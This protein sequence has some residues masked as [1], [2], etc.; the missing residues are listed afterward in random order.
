MRQHRQSGWNRNAV[1]ALSF[2]VLGAGIVAVLA[3]QLKSEGKRKSL[4]LVWADSFEEKFGDE[5][6][7]IRLEQPYH[8]YGESGLVSVLNPETR[9]PRRIAI[10]KGRGASAIQLT[11]LESWSFDYANSEPALLESEQLAF[12]TI[13]ISNEE[14]NSWKPAL[15]GPDEISMTGSGL[16]LFDEN[17]LQAYMLSD[18]E[19]LAK[20]TAAEIEKRRRF[21]WACFPL[22]LEDADHCKANVVYT[23]GSYAKPY[24]GIGKDGEI[25]CL[26]FDFGFL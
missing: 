24:L 15:E 18:P 4:D 9:A 1:L 11:I 3:T 25:V 8:I 22:D 7:R 26:T 16:V 5:T 2:A 12:L 23:G 14:P 21:D 6:R 17:C 20:R 13:R 10:G 19:A